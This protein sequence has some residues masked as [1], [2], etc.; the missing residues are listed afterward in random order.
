MKNYI[1]G[2]DIGGT[3]IKG[4]MIKYD[5]TLVASD[6]LPTYAENGVNDLVEIISR[7]VDGLIKQTG[8]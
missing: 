7:L 5:G 2:I 3:Y 4:G 6:K 8:R 1:I